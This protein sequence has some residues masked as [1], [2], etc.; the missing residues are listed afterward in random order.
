VTLEALRAWLAERPEALRVHGIENARV[1]RERAFARLLEAAPIDSAI[2]AVRSDP[3]LQGSLGV[4]PEDL[5]ALSPEYEVDLRESPGE[6][7]W[8]EASFVRRDLGGLRAFARPTTEPLPASATLVQAQKR[9]ANGE[10]DAAL[11]QF[12]SRS[13][14][15]FMVPSAIVTLERLPLTPNGKL[16]RKAL[17]A[18]SKARA[19]PQQTFK[20]PHSEL[21]Q[22]ISGVF[23]ALLG[24]TPI[25]VTDNFFDL[26]ANSLL[27][28]QA[29]ARLRT[30]L[31]RTVPLVDLYQHPTVAALAEHLAAS[32]GAAGPT[33]PA[34]AATAGQ[35]R[36]RARAQALNQRRRPKPA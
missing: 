36:A 31:E 27:V 5:F 18:P 7:G 32:D 12:L 28:M 24:V 34:S 4:H 25:S 14:P 2:D 17:P 33:Q 30:L 3:I 19:Q 35:A 29:T 11:K 23:E 26:G 22:R 8:L 21:E 15:D 20:A 16:D 13:L 6:P 9:S 1:S 10:L